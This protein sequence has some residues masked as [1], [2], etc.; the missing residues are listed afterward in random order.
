MPAQIWL[1]FHTPKGTQGTVNNM[2]LQ[3]MIQLCRGP[4]TARKTHIKVK[5]KYRRVHTMYIHSLNVYIHVCTYL[6]C[7]T[8]GVIRVSPQHN[9]S[10]WHFVASAA[11][12]D[13]KITIFWARTTL[14]LILHNKR[15]KR[16]ITLYSISVLAKTCWDN[17]YVNGLA[18]YVPC[19]YSVHTCSY[20]VYTCSYKYV[21]NFAYTT[22]LY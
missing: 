7:L 14:I 8:R 5:N 11:A 6:W 20:H 10:M 12:C 1:P 18:W 2:S 9:F 16:E 17:R 21:Q 3:N 22:A 4:T 15:G 13:K 19:T